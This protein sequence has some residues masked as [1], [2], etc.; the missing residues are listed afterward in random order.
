[1]IFPSRSEADIKKSI[2][3]YLKARGVIAFRMNAGDRYVKSAK[4]KM[5]RIMGHPSGTADILAFPPGSWVSFE[6]LKPGETRRGVTLP[7]ILWIEAK[8]STGK[9]SEEQ[10]LFQRIV[11]GLG[12][13]YILARSADDVAKVIG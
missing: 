12:H 11:E 6:G 1:M 3:E 9:Q 4:G 7:L 8:S 10:K 5:Y 13:R 2:M